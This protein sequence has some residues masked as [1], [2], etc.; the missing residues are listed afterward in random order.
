MKISCGREPLHPAEPLKF[1]FHKDMT[2][3]NREMNR[4]LSSRNLAST[5][6]LRL[7]LATLQLYQKKEFFK[8]QPIEVIS[9]FL[10][11]M[12]H[13]LHY[14]CKAPLCY[15]FCF[16]LQFVSTSPI[17]NYL[18]Y[19]FPDD[20]LCIYLALCFF[21]WY[22]KYICTPWFLDISVALCYKSYCF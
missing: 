13:S 19:A 17:Y 3:K 7:A 8:P 5:R 15:F 10:Q 14:S 1:S 21:V 18:K 12:A 22:E 4:I 20:P 6:S 2:L 16:I 11:F 9:S